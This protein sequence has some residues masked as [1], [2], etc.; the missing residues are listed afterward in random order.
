LKNCVIM[1]KARTGFLIGFLVFIHLPAIAQL[2]DGVMATQS[3]LVEIINNYNDENSYSFDLNAINTHVNI[4]LE[5]HIVMNIT[6]SAGVNQV[7]IFNSVALANDYFKNVGIQF[8][9]DTIDYIND[10]NYS[11]IT[12]NNLKKELLTKYAINSR[13]NLFLVDTIKMGSFQS[14]GFTYFPDEADSNFIY[15]DKHYL[16]GNSLTTMLGHF[17]GLLSTHEAGGGREVA[18]ENNCAASGD[19]ICD[20]YADPDL[21]NMVVDSCKYIGNMRDNNGQYYVPSVAN[22]MSNSPDNCKCIVTPLQY[23]RI[24][25]YYFK[26]RQYLSY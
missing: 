4:P 8:F 7:D 9:I 19:F 2:P 15:L 21:F 22:I 6:G 5:V 26:Y 1:N 23:R 10:Y 14:Y 12:Y 13:I 16:T 3:F 17:M 20:T 11:V 25:Y 24:Y 18:S